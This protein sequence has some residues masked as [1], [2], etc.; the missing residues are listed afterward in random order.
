VT[1][2]GQILEHGFLP[3]QPLNPYLVVSDKGSECSAGINID[4]Y[5]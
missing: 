3:L 4:G 1:T 2:V 5:S